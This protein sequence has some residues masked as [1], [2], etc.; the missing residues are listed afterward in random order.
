M[1]YTILFILFISIHARAMY[2]SSYI[3][4]MRSNEDFISKY[5]T[6]DTEIKNLYSVNTYPIE[7]PDNKN[8]VRLNTK[9]KEILYAP[10]RKT[11]EKKLTDSFKLYYRGPQDDKERYYRVTF[12]ETPLVLY[13]NKQ[14]SKSLTYLPS[15]ALSTILIVRP[16]KPKFEYILNEKQGYI[17]NT[18]NTFFRVIIH[19]GCNGKD[20]ESEQF[21]ML[22]NEE[23][24]HISITQENKKL[25]IFD[26][27]YIPVGEKCKRND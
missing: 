13:D 25:I 18:G 24:H 5:I 21:Y 1:K 9:D 22:P 17:R 15:I 4:E 20:E 27:R 12:T 16:R 14:T 10:L 11:I 19:K 3:Y 26:K 6:N 2:F 23:Y 7:R 8:E